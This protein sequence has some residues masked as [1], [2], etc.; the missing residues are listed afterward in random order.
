MRKSLLFSVAVVF[1]AGLILFSCKK[2]E[3]ELDP[4]REFMTSGA[5]SITS[6]ATNAVISWKEAVNTDSSSSTYTVEVSQDSTF[7][8]GA[9]FSYVVPGTTVTVTDTQLLI[10]TS[11]YVR[12]K[13]NGSTPA[14]DSKWVYSKK[15]SLTG[16]QIFMVVKDAEV[17]HNSVILRWNDSLHANLI[18]IVL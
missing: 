15:F 7:A 4:M 9:Q 5:I 14:L 3:N 8:T 13:T 16:E 18:K 2:K 1:L 11:Y 17:K 12:V 6:G 10:R